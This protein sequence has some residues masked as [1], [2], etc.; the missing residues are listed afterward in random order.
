MN[1]K[2][3]CSVAL[4]FV[5]GLSDYKTAQDASAFSVGQNDLVFWCDFVLV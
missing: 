2:R 1:K 4:I 5:H 3:V